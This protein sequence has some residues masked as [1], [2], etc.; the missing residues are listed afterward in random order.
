MLRPVGFVERASHR[1]RGAEKGDGLLQVGHILRG[2]GGGRPR[3]LRLVPCVT[4]CVC[5]RVCA[6]VHFNHGGPGHRCHEQEGAT[7]HPE[8][9]GTGDR[10]SVGGEM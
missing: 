3:S 4:L 1:G 6:Q 10:V 7:G 9:V 5:V 2:R 8:E